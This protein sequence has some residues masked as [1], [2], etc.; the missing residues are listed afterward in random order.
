MARV[1]QLLIKAQGET[2]AAQRE[3]KALQRSTRRFGDSMKGMG[4]SLTTAVTAP[5]AALGVLGV[6]ELRETMEVTK[7]TDAV[8]KSMG[9]SMKVTKNELQGLVS[10]LEAY[11]AI[12]GDIIQNAANVGLSF[13]ALAGNPELFK[14]TTRAAV[15]MSAALGMDLQQTMIQL[16]KAMQNGAKG[17]GALAKNGTLA[18]ADV[19]KLQQMAKDGLP[20]WKQQQY[21][22]Q[23]VNK[24]YAGQ[25]KNV[26]PIARITVAV[27]NVAE[28]LAVLLLPALEKVSGW[29]QRLADWV[30]GLS[31]AQKKWVG[32]L[33]LFAAAI[34]P[35]LM[36]M[37]SL[38]T[39]SATLIPMLAGITAPMLLIPVAIAALVAAMVV[40]YQR[41]E[42]FRAVV[43]SAFRGAQVAVVQ[44]V[45][46]LRSTLTT[47][48]RWARTLWARFGSDIMRVLRPAL[49]AVTTMVRTWVQNV[50]DVVLLVLAVLRGDWGRAW[51]LL[52]G[53]VSRTLS[54][55]V[56]VIR[57]FVKSA[58]SAVR[59]IGQGIGAL[60]SAFF[61]WGVNLGKAIVDGVKDGIRNIGS[62]IAERVRSA[63]GNARDIVTNALGKSARGKKTA[64]GPMSSKQ[65]QAARAQAVIDADAQKSFEQA[66]RQYNAGVRALA[67][68]RGLKD[69]KKRQEAVAAAQDRLAQLAQ[70]LVDKER[71]RNDAAQ[72]R[73][74][75]EKQA[76]A[77]AA[78]EKQQA[79]LDAEE[80]RRRALGLMSMQEEAE[81]AAVN[82]IRAQHGLAPV[83]NMTSISGAASQAV[84][85][86][87]GASSSTPTQQVF[88]IMVRDEIDLDALVQRLQ[89]RSR[90]VGV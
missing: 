8:F 7:K 11:S 1:W 14:A 43:Q 10:E 46:S 83:T 67:S 6:S 9:A 37:G 71:A 17:A 20:I 16:G 35:L 51:E 81:L 36:V 63:A 2:A 32:V 53:I 78:Q 28:S 24:Q 29:V 34:G 44:V 75:T 74:E 59:S 31:A 25:G 39:A 54:A 88:Q 56:S 15:D 90:R 48:A 73:L 58:V 82:K 84:A 77:D 27:K 49:A 23:A 87:S 70:N 30:S 3:L 62:S 47:W 68:A 5:I 52:K 69:K 61:Q 38:I 85:S 64:F 55:V 13:K 42:K 22:L 12:D 4:R 65:L 45:N 76:A 57:N 86:T 19:E 79:Q 72:E 80:F 41:S 50:R 21:I 40:A 33:L 89:M 26:D 66:V 60:R 18:K